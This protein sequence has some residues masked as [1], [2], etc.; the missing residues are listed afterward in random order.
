MSDD[1]TDDTK[2]KAA[3]PTK[4]NAASVL[5][6]HANDSLKWQSTLGYLLRGP[7]HRFHAE[8]WGDHALH[9]TV[10]TLEQKHGL[11]IEREWREVPTRFGKPCRVKAYWVAELSREHATRLVSRRKRTKNGGEA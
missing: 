4:E 2:T 6:L 10:S 9:S 8:R 7:R 11:Q 5:E 1:L 3:P